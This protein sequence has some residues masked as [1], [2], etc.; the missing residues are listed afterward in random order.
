MALGVNVQ[1][2]PSQAQKI[3]L[4][5]MLVI[6]VAAFVERY[7]GATQETAT[8]PE[9]FVGAFVGTALLLFLSYFMPEFAVGLAVVTMLAMI[10]AKGQPFWDAINKIFPKPAATPATP[11]APT[12]GSNTASISP[13]KPLNG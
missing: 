9:I 11:N 5:T 13:Q 8:V 4:M 2:Q 6:V 10:I 12:P 7:S 1:F 3:I